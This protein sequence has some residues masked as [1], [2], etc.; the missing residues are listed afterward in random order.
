M[1]VFISWSGEKSRRI[2]N[3]IHKWLPSVIQA[4]RPYYSPD[5]VAKGTRWA[6]EIAAELQASRVGLLIL[7]KDNT[8]APWLLFEA[9]ALSKSLDVARVC[10][11]LFGL[12][13]TDIKGPLVQFQG[14]KFDANEMKR[15]V[16]MM[17]DQLGEG[18]LS[19]EVLENVFTKWWPELDQRVNEILAEVQTEHGASRPERDMLEE[20]LSLVRSTARGRAMPSRLSP[21]A[22]A[23]LLG[24]QKELESVCVDL[25]SPELVAAIAHLRRPVDYLKR[26]ALLRESLGHRSVSSEIKDDEPEAGS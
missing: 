1:K 18:A 10:P 16:K 3:E 11:L 22:I 20:I 7:T 4:I 21:A 25:D 2:A 8:E 26:H 23:D 14:A 5:D 15:V 9:G 24:A 12:E 17:N 13:P 6:A 19:P